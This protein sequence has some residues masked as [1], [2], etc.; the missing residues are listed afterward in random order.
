MLSAMMSWPQKNVLP[1]IQVN[2]GGKS[3]KHAYMIMAHY[4]VGLLIELLKCLDHEDN[5]IIIHFDEKSH[6]YP[7][8]ISGVCKKSQIYF[9]DRIAVQWGGYS[10][11]KAILA[12][13]QKAC[14]VGTHGY[15]HL[16]SGVDLPLKNIVFVNEF[17]ER[18]TGKQFINF[19]DK[20]FNDTVYDR[21]LKYRNFFRERCGRKK[22]IWWFFNKAGIVGQEI[23]DM[24][25]KIIKKDDF[26]TGSGWW[27]ITEEL[28][29]D[30]LS[31]RE[32]IENTYKYS[33]CCDEAFVQ[34]YV[35]NSKYKDTLFCPYLG[36]GRKGN[37]RWIDWSR[38]TPDGS[39]HTINENDVESLFESEMLFARK[40][41]I[42][43]FPKAVKEI[44]KCVIGSKV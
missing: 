16:L 23:L 19:S 30:L 37:M 43:K 5:D 39:P 25:T 33:S 12:C 13:L 44:V 8:M 18:S 15:Y 38:G 29:N 20:S 35:M 32:W 42:D 7:E 27:S 14:G 28:A 4:Q 24:P 22:N 17:F 10:Q 3:V 41:D 34:T 36:N 31:E 6:L 21:R 26:Y 2:Y 9:A 11:I 1:F 40:F